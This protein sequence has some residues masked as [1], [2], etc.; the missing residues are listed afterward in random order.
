MNHW[1]FDKQKHNTGTLLLF[2]ALPVA[3]F[4]VGEKE[5]ILGVLALFFKKKKKKEKVLAF[6]FRLPF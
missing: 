3:L 1:T 5:K 2:E 4:F 6:S